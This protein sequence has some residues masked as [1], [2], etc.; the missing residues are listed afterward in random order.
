MMLLENDH[1]EKVLPLHSDYCEIDRLDS[2]SILLSVESF[3]LWQLLFTM[4]VKTGVCLGISLQ[5]DLQEICLLFTAMTLDFNFCYEM[6]QFLKDLELKIIFEVLH[7]EHQCR[8][9]MRF[10][11]S[12]NKACKSH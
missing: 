12:F 6:T 10:L 3:C 5:H 4:N 1:L 9:H 11:C 7:F 8:N 2:T